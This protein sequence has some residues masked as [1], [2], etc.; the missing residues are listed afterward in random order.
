M[1]LVSWIPKSTEFAVP[2][3]KGGFNPPSSDGVPAI[4][5]GQAEPQPQRKQATCSVSRRGIS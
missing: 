3:K 1:L 5:F 4:G 2:M